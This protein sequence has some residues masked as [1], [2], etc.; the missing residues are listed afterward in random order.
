MHITH[1][2]A[3]HTSQST[4]SFSIRPFT[5]LL[6]PR[7]VM[8]APYSENHMKHVH[9]LRDKIQSSVMLQQLTHVVFRMLKLASY[10]VVRQVIC[11]DLDT[12]H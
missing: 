5:Y 2:N 12:L 9:T 1:K 11:N 10:F 3:V 8:I 4:V 7:R 6:T